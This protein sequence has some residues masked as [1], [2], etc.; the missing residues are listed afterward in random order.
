MAISTDLDLVFSFRGF[1]FFFL[2][3]SDPQLLVSQDERATA[4][5]QFGR[6]QD[7]RFSLSILLP[8]FSLILLVPR[9]QSAASISMECLPKLI[10]MRFP[11]SFLLFFVPFILV[12]S[13]FPVAGSLSL[14]YCASYPI[15]AECYKL[16]NAVR[17]TSCL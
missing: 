5:L 12:L 7:A 6:S 10:E 14:A 9:Q 16:N 8:F 15:P 11:C 4:R 3:C 17:D 1:F 2:P 13:H